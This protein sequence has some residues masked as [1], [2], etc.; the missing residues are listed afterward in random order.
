MVAR[1][2][3]VRAL[4]L[5]AT[6]L[7]WEWY[8]RG[9]DPIFLSYPTGILLAV[10]QMIASG[11]LQSAMA[12]SLTQFAI[13]FGLAIVFGVLVGLITG[14]YRMV[15][16]AIDLQ[17]SALYATPNVALIP[18]FMLWF[19][20]GA[21]AKI[22]II[23]MAAFFPIVVTTQAGVKNVS[24]S[25]VDIVLAEGASEWQVITKVVIPASLPFVMGG[26]RLGVGRAVVGM[27]VAE[28]FTA[29]TGLGGL[30]VTY[31]NK[32]QTDRL[33]VIIICLALLGVGMTQGLK[34]LELRLAR[35]KATERAQ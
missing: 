8:G 6:L 3:V 5:I 27:V 13:G 2:S 17:L 11:E 34:R 10:P 35:W 12:S 14:R 16:Y 31:G 23:F 9:V 4:S 29:I 30:I 26:I 18:L 32:F 22:F 25:L 20:L 7:V 33:F 21:T 24:A 28:M 19:G 1:P 15:E